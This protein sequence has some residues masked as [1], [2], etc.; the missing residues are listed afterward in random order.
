MATIGNPNNAREMEEA[1]DIVVREFK[2]LKRNFGKVANDR[3]TY[4]F[5]EQQDTDA[6]LTFNTSKAKA[7]YDNAVAIFMNPDVIPEPEPEPDI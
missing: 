5:S 7:A 1:C 2:R 3:E 6:L 4:S